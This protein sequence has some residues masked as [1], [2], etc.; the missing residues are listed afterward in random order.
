MAIALR[1]S[2]EDY[3]ARAANSNARA[4]NGHASSSKERTVDNIA[5]EIREF[6]VKKARLEAE[7][8][9]VESCLQVLYQELEE[10]QRTESAV[11]ARR[12]T[13]GK[14]KAGGI[15]YNSSEFEWSGALEAKLKE[16]FGHDSFRLCQEG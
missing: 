6:E 13:K 7:K 3:H 14:S 12:D 1:L 10:K 8:A 16:V 5:A 11:F 15:D 4:P 2:L 9:R